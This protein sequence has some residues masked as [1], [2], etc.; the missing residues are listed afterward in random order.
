MSLSIRNLVIFSLFCVLIST[1]SI[2]RTLRN[3]NKGENKH[4]TS[5]KHYQQAPKT[6]NTFFADAQN[7][8]NSISTSI[9]PNVPSI[10]KTQ[11]LPTYTF[12][13]NTCDTLNTQQNSQT[14]DQIRQTK[15]NIK[16]FQNNV[17]DPQILSDANN[18]YSY[19]NTLERLA[20]YKCS[21][22]TREITIGPSPYQSNL[23][24]KR[25]WIYGGLKQADLVK[26]YTDRIAK[27]NN[28]TNCG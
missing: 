28:V 4:Q 19:L 18:S 6:S 17:K 13:R 7:I 2:S 9:Q 23:N 12:T 26:D 3:H 11:N 15:E 8:A 25:A 27:Y 5:S 24:T 20:S 21:D 1:V 16:K 10:I 22:L 14:L